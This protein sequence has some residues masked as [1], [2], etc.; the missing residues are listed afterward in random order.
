M[1]TA[2]SAPE[3]SEPPDFSEES[4][5]A[6]EDTAASD[7]EDFNESSEDDTSETAAA[8]SPEEEPQP[9]AAPGVISYSGFW[10]RYGA[11]FIDNIILSIGG[12]IYYALVAGFAQLFALP[13]PPELFTGIGFMLLSMFYFVALVKCFGGTLGK[14]LLKCKVVDH[15][16]HNLLSWGQACRRVF[17]SILYALIIAGAVLHYAATQPAP[18]PSAPTPEFLTETEAPAPTGLVS[19]PES[20]TDDFPSYLILAFLVGGFLFLVGY[21]MSLFNEKRRTLHDFLSGAVV[22]NNPPK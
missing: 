15:Q 13:A 16:T 21:L 4:P 12:K 3:W 8:A 1:S 10:R 20:A 11:L 19:R 22:I 2:P 6:T 9:P 14:Q 7:T 5:P 18:E 17:F